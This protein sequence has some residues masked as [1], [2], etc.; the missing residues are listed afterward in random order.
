MSSLFLFVIAVD[1][2][3]SIQTFIR[4]CVA[5]MKLQNER[6]EC[7]CRASIIIYMSLTILIKWNALTGSDIFRLRTCLQT[8]SHD[9]R[10]YNNIK[11]IILVTILKYLSWT[12]AH[13]TVLFTIGQL[14]SL[15]LDAWINRVITSEVKFTTISGFV[16]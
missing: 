2:W 10:K 8:L 6:G 12:C 16:E 14:N 13:P 15:L 3:Q 5:A 9:T 1:I 11:T 4:K 7:P